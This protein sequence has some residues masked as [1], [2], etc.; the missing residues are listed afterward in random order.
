MTRSSLGLSLESFRQAWFETHS[1]WL[2]SANL[3]AWWYLS[4]EVLTAQVEGK[5]HS[6]ARCQSWMIKADQR[7]WYADWC[8]CHILVWMTFAEELDLIMS[9]TKYCESDKDQS[10][11]LRANISCML[12]Y[13]FHNAFSSNN[14]GQWVSNLGRGTWI[15]CWR[16]R[17]SQQ[18][19]FLRAPTPNI[20]TCNLR[21]VWPM[22]SF[23]AFSNLRKLILP[24]KLL[25]RY[26]FLFQ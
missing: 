21:L 12:S 2:G 22:I 6:E 24:N 20:G 25:V 10:A 23:V 8:W 14:H 4:P 17:L 15:P 18:M 1:T 26:I 9:R 7:R 5:V 19:F 11:A 13:F 16:R 3:Q